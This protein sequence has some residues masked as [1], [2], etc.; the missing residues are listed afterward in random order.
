MWCWPIF[1]VRIASVHQVQF[2]RKLM[3]PTS[4]LQDTNLARVKAT[5]EYLMTCSNILIVANISRAVTDQSLKSA[6]F[7]VVS[8][9]APME[10]EESAASSLNICVVCT[11][12]DVSAFDHS[13][14]STSML[15]VPGNQ[16]Q[17]SKGRVLRSWKTHRPT[18][19]DT[20]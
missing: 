9:H 1:Q 10:W 15:I 17:P 14:G 2:N 11:K 18:R 19:D 20:A 6:I 12:I 7:S 5:Q 13:L 16:P 4:G 3:I 8:R